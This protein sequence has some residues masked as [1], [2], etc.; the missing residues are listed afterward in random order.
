[1]IS[2][3]SNFSS[4][5]TEA[6]YSYFTDFFKAVEQGN[7]E[8]VKNFLE[9]G[10]SPNTFCDGWS[11]LFKATEKRDSAMVNILLDQGADFNLPC[12][13][14][15]TPLEKAQEL[16]CDDII[17]AMNDHAADKDNDTKVMIQD[18]VVITGQVP[19]DFQSDMNSLLKNRDNFLNIAFKNK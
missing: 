2:S 14:G 7:H 12:A 6:R 9:N 13:N 17:K 16:G 1:M 11:V 18:T 8:S 19:K 3:L 5:Y 15:I 4:H 10:N